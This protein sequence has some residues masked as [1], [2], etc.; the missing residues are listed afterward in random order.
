MSAQS[1]GFGEKVRA[2][3]NR[4]FWSQQDLSDRANVSVRTIQ[5]IENGISRQ[6]H[7]QTARA[8]AAALEIELVGADA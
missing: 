8:L 6:P 4:R 2:E 3:R 5:N 7:G 1:N